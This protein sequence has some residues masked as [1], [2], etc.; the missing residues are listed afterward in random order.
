MILWYYIMICDMRIVS[1]R[2]WC[3]HSVE[4]WLCI[5]N[6]SS[7]VA[8]SNS[9][10]NMSTHYT[11]GGTSQVGSCLGQTTFLPT[12]LLSE[13]GLQVFSKISVAVSLQVSM[14]PCIHWQYA[15][16]WTLPLLQCH[17]PL[18]ILALEWEWLRWQSSYGKIIFTR[19]VWLLSF[20]VPI[21][22]YVILVII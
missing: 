6:S 15:T 20:S 7:S 10:L 14:C 9:Q 21:K 8:R 4:V 1:G 3:S 17:C 16:W 5:L 18:D 19:N 11:D 2:F 13:C 12:W 22:L